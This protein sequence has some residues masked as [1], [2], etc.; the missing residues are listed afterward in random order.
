MNR[1]MCVAQVV[2]LVVVSVCALASPVLAQDCPELVGHLPGGGLALD[3]AVSGGYAY[4]ADWDTGF[5]VIDVS[6][7]SAPVEVGF[8][9]GPGLQKIAVSDGYAFAAGGALILFVID[10]S[11]PS[12]PVVVGWVELRG[13]KGRRNGS[14]STGIAVSG[15][16]VYTTQWWAGALGGTRWLA[17]IDVTDPSAPVKVGSLDDVDGDIALDGGYAYIAEG[18]GLR[19][20]DVSTPTA[21]AEVGFLEGAGGA[22]AVAGSSAYVTYGSGGHIGSGGLVVID[23]SNV[24]AP[25]ELGRVETPAR[26]GDLA[27]SNGLAYVAATDG[28]RVFDVSWPSAPSERGHYWVGID[29][30]YPLDF[31]GGAAVADGFVF[32]AAGEAGL[33]VFRECRPASVPDP[34]ESFIPAAAYAAGAEGAFFETDV[35]LNNRGTEEAQVVFQWLPRGEDNSAP[36]ESAPLT[37]APGHSVRYANVLA[38]LFGL[39]PDAYGALKLV[40]STEQVLGMSRTSTSAGGGAP[41]TFGQELPAIRSTDMISGTEP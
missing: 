35:E 26:A 5:R 12:A 34:R 25:V 22:V 38:E 6:T 15:S 27:I 10:V 4:V 19:V 2:A 29:F 1:Q 41:G 3:V 11:T 7:P 23:V 32:L 40:A 14:S 18:N 31:F 28:L 24:S 16:H 39:V 30:D 20:I 33:Y 17:V 37:L 9:D 13:P 8:L 21:P 36:L